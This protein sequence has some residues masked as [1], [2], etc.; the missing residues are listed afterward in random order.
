MSISG[1]YY[2]HENGDLIWKRYLDGGQVADFRESPFVKMFWPL[3]LENRYDAW[4]TLVEAMAM[5]ADTAR[6]KELAEKWRCDDEDAKHFAN[7]FGV[8][9]YMDG[10]KWCAVRADFNDLATSPAGFGD[11][12]LEAMA[13]LLNEC[14]FKPSKT[15]GHT[16]KDVLQAAPQ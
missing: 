3:D 12:C 5:K 14:G 1:Y 10:D 13:E 9:L 11:T 8:D 16:I 15:W 7:C 6:I 4:R 2:L